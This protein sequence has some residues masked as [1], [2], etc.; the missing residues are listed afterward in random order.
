M[1]IISIYNKTSVKEV[2]KQ[3]GGSPQVTAT[4]SK[5][6]L[7][8]VWEEPSGFTLYRR[9]LKTIS[10]TT[11]QELGSQVN[12]TLDTH[13]VEDNSDVPRHKAKQLRTMNSY[14]LNYCGYKANNRKHSGI[15][16]LHLL[17][18]QLTVHKHMS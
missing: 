12:T 4:E 18:T 15:C 14:L 5:A 6:N 16:L 13:R 9:L 2:L 1:Q 11:P 10:T 17:P 7:S 3:P 8:V